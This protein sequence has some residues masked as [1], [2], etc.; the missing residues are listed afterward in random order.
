VPRGAERTHSASR[1]GSSFCELVS[2]SPI[3]YVREIA[4]KLDA[5]LEL[6]TEMGGIH[7][8]GVD[9]IR[10]CERSRRWQYWTH[11]TSR[12]LAATGT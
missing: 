3:R 6:E 12:G 2:Q 8:N 7:L 10:T 5:A 11:L 9:P 4:G 1:P